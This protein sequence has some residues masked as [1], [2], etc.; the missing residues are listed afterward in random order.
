MRFIILGSGGRENA[1]IRKLLEDTTTN[2]IFISN[3]INPDI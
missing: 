3:T 1:I 2:I